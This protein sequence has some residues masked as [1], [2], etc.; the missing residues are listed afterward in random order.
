MPAHALS[1]SIAD[2]AVS[3]PISSLAPG[4]TYHYA[5]R[6]TNARGTSTSADRTFV[7]AGT[8]APPT[9]TTSPPAA[10]VV[11]KLSLSPTTLRP[12]TKGAMIA[13]AARGA[14]LTIALTAPAKVTFSVVRRQTGVRVGKRCL[15]PGHGRHGKA[16][17][18]ITTL[19][20][21]TTKALAKGTSTLRFSARVAGHA[22]KPG[23]YTLR[24]TPAG[25][26]AR[27]IR[28]RVAR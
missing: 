18:R 22:L 10:A 19:A 21:K 7:T 1:R 15:A 27:E 5:L 26:K 4:T 11:T 6:V 16:C 3:D 2:Q 17:T 8:A 25:G 23:S 14:K 9:T 12:L 24:A 28:F 13:V 20:G